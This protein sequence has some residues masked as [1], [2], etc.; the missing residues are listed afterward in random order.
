M[1]KTLKLFI[2]DV[3]NIILYTQYVNM[4]TYRNRFMHDTYI[5]LF[6]YTV[7]A[8]RLIGVESVLIQR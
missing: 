3:L 5:K 1:K 7:G 2:D 6:D 4:M 8:Q